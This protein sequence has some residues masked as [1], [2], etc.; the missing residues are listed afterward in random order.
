M[1][2]H[3][4]R[5]EDGTLLGSTCACT[6]SS[7][8]PSH[9]RTIT[10]SHICTIAPDSPRRQPLCLVSTWAALLLLTQHAYTAKLLSPRA[11]SA[12]AQPSCRLSTCPALMPVSTS[13]ALM[14][15][16]R[17]RCLQSMKHF[18]LTA[19]HQAHRMP[20]GSLHAT[21]PHNPCAGCPCAVC[22]VCPR[23]LCAGCL[24]TS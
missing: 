10:P 17:M 23:C 21:S 18:Q 16:Q 24:C 8:P 7:H 3:R 20:P 4:G 11:G 13:A 12:H 2:T 14:P 9:H 19:C 5:K 15:A 22:V 6:H 1:S